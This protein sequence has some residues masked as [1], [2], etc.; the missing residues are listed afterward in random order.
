MFRQRRRILKLKFSYFLLFAC[1][2]FLCSQDAPP[3]EQSSQLEN[4]GAARPRIPL[5]VQ[6]PSPSDDQQQQAGPPAQGGDFSNNFDAGKVPAGVILVKGAWASSSDS[7]TPEPEGGGI[8]DNRYMNKYFGLVWN[9]PP[10]WFQKFDGPPPS[11]G[12]SYVLAQLRPAD[13]FKGPTKGTVLLSAQDLF[14]SAV[15]AKNALEMLRVRRG[16]LPAGY[17]VVKSPEEVTIAN[18]SFARMD[19]TAPV[20]GIHWTILATEIRC[21]AVQFTLTGRDPALLDSIVRT[22]EKMELPDGVG[23][24]YGKGGGDYPVCIKNYALGPNLASKVDPI[25]PPE[26]YN[27]IPVRIIIGKSGKVTHV[28]LISAFPD[29]A[30]IIT[31]A[32]LQW[33]FKPYLINGEAVEVETGIM[34]G[35]GIRRPTARQTTA[36][37]D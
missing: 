35:R 30:K 11:D 12:G 31:D 26:K 25:L 3:Q 14:F 5:P 23:A 24:T 4:S 20:S 17:V 6:S 16:A 28:H 27:Q 9:L 19:Y 18:H 36:P 37:A 1:S 10:D 32:L 22:I 33:E 34:L 8:V 7:I 2:A 21:H 15:P 13:T 29:Q